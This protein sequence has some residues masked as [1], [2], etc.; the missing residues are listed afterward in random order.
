MTEYNA[1]GNTTRRPCHSW[2]AAQGE[3]ARPAEPCAGARAE[4]LC[5]ATR[6]FRACEGLW[7][8]TPVQ[9]FPAVTP[10]RSF[11]NTRRKESRPRSSHPGRSSVFFLLALSLRCFLLAA[12]LLTGW[13][14]LLALLFL[15]RP[16]LLGHVDFLLWCSWKQLG[17]Q[18][19]SLSQEP[20][21]REHRSLRG[22]SSSL[23]PESKRRHIKP[24]NTPL[25]GPGRIQATHC[26]FFQEQ[27]WSYLSCH[28]AL[29]FQRQQLT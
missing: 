11:V 22:K 7:P 15:R 19:T 26:P 21:S 12:G 23:T 9:L 20:R 10:V 28:K 13:C 3:G 14:L 8:L 17:L 29:V 27:R 5:S 18:N 25:E 16:R 2:P 4:P 6:G 1:H 24:P